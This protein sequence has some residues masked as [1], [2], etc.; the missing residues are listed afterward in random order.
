MFFFTQFNSVEKQICK[1]KSKI[2][3]LFEHPQPAEQHF[4]NNSTLLSEADF[5]N[6]KK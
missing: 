4:S 6:T 1:L 2:N 5:K 3:I